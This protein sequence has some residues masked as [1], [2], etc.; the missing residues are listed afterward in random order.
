MRI[1]V[2]IPTYNGAHKIVHTLAALQKQTYKNF[3]VVVVI[4]RSEDDTL[5]RINGGNFGLTSLRV[6]IQENRGRAGNRNSGAKE[7][8]GELLIFFDD[9]MRPIPE[10]VALHAIHHQNH[11]KTIAVGSQIEEWEQMKTDI[12]QYKAYLS[13]KWLAPL[14]VGQGLIPASQPFLTAANFSI[15]KDLFMHLGGF[16]ENLSDAEDFDLAVRAVQLETPIYFLSKAIAWHDDFLTCRSYIQRQRQYKVANQRLRR[17]KPSLYKD[18]TQYVFS[19]VKG[20]KRFIYG[21][22][23]HR[24]SVLLIDHTFIFKVF[25]KSLRY[26]LY[27][28]IITGLSVYFPNRSI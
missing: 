16:D 5:Q 4:G 1:S 21:V 17:S 11:I 9:D 2:I 27:S 10:C 6:I 14:Q 26:K 20:L 13:R 22:L 19:E 25:P 24:F 8:K 12:Q 23:S 7:A 28:V 3:E 18:Q 15:S